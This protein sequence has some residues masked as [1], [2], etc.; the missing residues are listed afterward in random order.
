M[1]TDG[2]TARIVWLQARRESVTDTAAAADVLV[3]QPEG[4]GLEGFSDLRSMRPGQVV[5]GGHG[6]SFPSRSS[7][8]RRRMTLT[9]RSRSSPRSKRM[10]V[11]MLWTA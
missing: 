4:D 8:V 11:G 9:M 5:L 2:A 7:M 10:R 6:T 3:E 1:T